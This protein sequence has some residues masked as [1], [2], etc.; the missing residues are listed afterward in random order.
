MLGFTQIS[1]DNESGNEKHPDS[2]FKEWEK[3]TDEEKAAAADLGFTE[4]DWERRWDDD[5]G[6]EPLPDSFYK[7]WAEL[8]SCGKNRFLLHNPCV[9][10]HSFLQMNTSVVGYSDSRNRVVYH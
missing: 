6:S 2:I 9:H 5:Q 1:W 8:T 3:L 10:L 7:P 4:R